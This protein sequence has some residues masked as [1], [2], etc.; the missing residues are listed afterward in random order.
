MIQPFLTSF[1]SNFPSK[2]LPKFQNP[3]KILL[4]TNYWR[5]PFPKFKI[6]PQ[7]LFSNLIST[8]TNIFF[9]KIT[10]PTIFVS[11]FPIQTSSKIS[12]FLQNPSLNKLLNSSFSIIQN[13]SSI[14]SSNLISTLTKFFSKKL[15]TPPSS[16]A[17]FPS[18]PLPKFQNFFKIAFQTNYWTLPFQKFKISPP[19]P[20]QTQLQPLQKFFFEKL[21]TP[22]SSPANFPYK[23]F[24]QLRN[25][26]K[27]SFSKKKKKN[28]KLSHM[29]PINFLFP[30][31][32]LSFFSLL[33]FLN[34]NKKT[35]YRYK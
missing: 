2:T 16:S 24:P 13:F 22:P 31:T 30:P 10:Y 33:V 32:Y 19:F 34:H 21:P 3:F 15:P 1:P 23:T 14:S 26:Q 9:Q 29:F 4:Q 25:L 28:S 8:L 11:K 6:S 35:M 7:F 18:K 17:N 27:N 12:K 20:L 5:L